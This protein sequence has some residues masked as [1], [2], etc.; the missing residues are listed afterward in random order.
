MNVKTKLIKE[1]AYNLLKINNTVTTLE[2]KNECINIHPEFYWKQEDISNALNDLLDEND[3]Y[4]S[5]D[6][7]TYRTYS[8]KS[9]TKFPSMQ[10]VISKPV[11]STP[12]TI[13]TQK[14]GRRKVLETLESAKGKFITVS[15]IKKDKTDRT[16]NC[17]YMGKNDLGYAEVIE[18]KSKTHKQVNLQT[19]Y[20]IKSDGVIY[21][22]K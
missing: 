16:M 7:G 20:S 12:K 10:L 11:K 9:L 4:I 1:A 21:T 22:V 3:L 2:V 18:T 17:K 8:A 6:N 13:T 15:F 19:I 14:I 5:N